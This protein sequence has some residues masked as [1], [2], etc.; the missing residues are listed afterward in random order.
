MTLQYLKNSLKKKPDSNVLTKNDKILQ[1]SYVLRFYWLEDRS[2]GNNT[3]GHLE[4]DK[5]SQ[6]KIKRIGPILSWHTLHESSH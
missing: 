2:G 4:I 5:V 6:S 3:D 1:N